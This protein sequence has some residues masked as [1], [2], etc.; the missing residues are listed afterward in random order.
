MENYPKTILELE[1]KFSTE[2]ACVQ[3][4]SAIKWAEGFKCPKCGKNKYWQMVNDL[5]M[6]ASCHH[7][8]SVKAGT[9]YQDSKIELQ[10][11]F[12]AAW[13]LIGQKNGCSAKGLQRVL[14]TYS[15]KYVAS[16]KSAGF[17]FVE[18]AAVKKT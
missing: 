15:V 2:S 3:Y 14:G 17:F 9:I 16:L 6:C 1:K 18:T 13:W 10:I 8:T 4:L 7:Q 5:F 11:W 12:R